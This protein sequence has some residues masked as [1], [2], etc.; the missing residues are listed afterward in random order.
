MDEESIR[1]GVDVQLANDTFQDQR[2]S[3]ETEQP[4][5]DNNLHSVNETAKESYLA[6][7]SRQEPRQHV[8]HS[9]FHPADTCVIEM[10]P[11]EDE[12]TMHNIQ[13][14]SDHNLH[15]VNGTAKESYLASMLRQELGQHNN[16]NVIHIDPNADE[17]CRNRPPE[18]QPQ[19]IP[20]GG[21]IWIPARWWYRHGGRIW[22]PGWWDCVY[23]TCSLDQFL[24][25]LFQ[26]F[27]F[28][29]LLQLLEELAGR[30]PESYMHLLV[31]VRLCM[32]GRSTVAKIHLLPYVRDMEGS[33]GERVMPHIERQLCHRI[34]RRCEGCHDSPASQLVLYNIYLSIF[35]LSTGFQEAFRS[36]FIRHGECRREGCGGRTISNVIF[37]SGTPPLILAV[38]L[39]PLHRHIPNSQSVNDSEI[40][41]L[42]GERYMM[43]LFTFFRPGKEDLH[44]QGHYM[45][46]VFIPE[47]RTDCVGRPAG[48]WYDYPNNQYGDLD[49]CKTDQRDPPGT[50]PSYVYFI[51]LPAPSEAAPCTVQGEE[52]SPHS[53]DNE[54]DG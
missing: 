11:T 50:F 12:V 44:I 30:F 39:I 14:V 16:Q 8:S 5:P 28:R 27:R 3:N 19:G 32:E 29:P 20:H 23:N 46:R 4:V 48:R 18:N 25:G 2:C 22:I 7:M 52:E 6:S 35:N 53:E 15:P 51:R 49:P 36:Y 37:E 26:I 42:F 38:N 45:S 41:E 21:S 43:F 34:I 33:E 1:R 31:A 10:E 17:D 40:V 54:D 47:G 13:P 24:N 9:K